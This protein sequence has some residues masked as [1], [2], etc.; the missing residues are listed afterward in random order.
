M[1]IKQIMLLLTLLLLLLQP[2]SVFAQSVQDPLVF[3]HVT[4]H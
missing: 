4:V 2:K 3:T 1:A